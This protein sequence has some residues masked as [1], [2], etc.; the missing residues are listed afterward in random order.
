MPNQLRERTSI[1]P[2]PS[3]DSDGLPMMSS[4]GTALENEIL[5]LP[6]LPFRFRWPAHGRVGDG[7]ALLPCPGGSDRLRHHLSIPDG[8]GG[9]PGPRGLAIADSDV[10]DRRGPQP[11]R[12]SEAVTGRARPYRIERRGEALGV[13]RLPA[14]AGGHPSRRVHRRRR[15]GRG[16]G[17]GGFGGAPPS[18]PPAPGC[19]PQPA[20]PP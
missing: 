16:S 13:V 20:C 19:P 3:C 12:R 1:P 10:V 11:L 2:R 17:A 15:G 8:R 18:A 9:R 6:E 7:T 14:A 5:S 4:G